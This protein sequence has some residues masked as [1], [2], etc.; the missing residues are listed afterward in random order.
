[1]P[2]TSWMKKIISIIKAK[3]Y[4]RVNQAKLEKEQW[5]KDRI[6]TCN[7]CPLQSDNFQNKKGIMF[8]IIRV[9]NFNNPFCTICGCE[10]KAK[11]SS[12]IEDC[13]KNKWEKLI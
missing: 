2:N 12:Q 5:Y 10:I 1:M 13:P 3:Y 9:L 11:A 7:D 8:N 6:K 4:S